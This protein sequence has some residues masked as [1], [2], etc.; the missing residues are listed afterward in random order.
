MT[1]ITQFIASLGLNELKVWCEEA[2]KT[3]R[4]WDVI[5]SN[6]LAI[7]RSIKVTSIKPSGS[8]SLLPGVTAGC[9]FA[10]SR[11]HIRRVRF[12]KDPLVEE[13]RKAGYDVE[14]CKLL[15]STT[16]IVSFPIDMGPIRS[17]DQVSMWEQLQ[18]AAFL[19]RYYADNQ[20][21]VTLTFR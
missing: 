14:P 3:I 15:P 19:Q 5:Y 16:N 9:H 8:I 6:W 1:G 17:V 2:Y 18:L 4:R 7:P 11:Y 10:E 21:S 12:G 13:L 20:V